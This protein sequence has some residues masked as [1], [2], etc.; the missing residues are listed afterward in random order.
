VTK[1]N[2]ALAGKTRFPQRYPQLW[3]TRRIIRGNALS[4]CSGSEELQQDIGFLD[5]EGGGGY[6]FP[7]LRRN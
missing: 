2:V 5:S 7:V 3:K 6:N 4:P 1:R